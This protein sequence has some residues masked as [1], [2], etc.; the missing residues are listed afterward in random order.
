[1]VAKLLP[2]MKCQAIFLKHR[3][4]II[5]SNN[6]NVLQPSASNL[7]LNSSTDQP[8]TSASSLNHQFEANNGSI[9]TLVCHPDE[10]SPISPS[11]DRSITSKRPW[12]V[13]YKLPE[14]PPK[15][16]MA[17]ERK[18]PVFKQIGRNALRTGLI[19]TLFDDMSTYTWLEIHFFIIE[20]LRNLRKYLLLLTCLI[21]L[22]SNYMIGNKVKQFFA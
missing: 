21:L 15:L 4:E 1:M 19:Q 17:Y 6:K 3:N 12:P 11:Q 10:I 22:V 13:L 7:N 16:Q 20:M 14:M 18:D 5:L 2:T 8:S 9:A